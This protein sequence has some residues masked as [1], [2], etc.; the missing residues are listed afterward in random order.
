MSVEQIVSQCLL[1]K[2]AQC[3]KYCPIHT[4]IPEVM[5]LIKEGKIEEAKAVLFENN[6][7][8]AVCAMVCD[9]AAQCYGH[10]IK[11]FKN[12]P[13]PFFEIEQILSRQYLFDHEFSGRPSL[14]QRIGI[15]GGGPAGITAAIKLALKGYPITIF[16]AKER[17]GGVLRYGIP[18]VRLPKNLIDRLEELLLSLNVKIRP[19]TLIG[20]VL[21]IDRLLEDG[22]SALFIG[23]GVWNPKLLNI[24]GE[25]LGN[26]HYAIDYL[27]SPEAY[28]LDHEVAVIGAGNVAMDAAREARRLGHQVTVYYRRSLKQMSASKEE[29]EAAC[30]EG[31]VFELQNSPVRIEED[32]LWLER[33]QVDEEG[34]ISTIPNSLHK[35]SC[36]SVIIAVSQSPR[37]NIVDH[38]QN[39][40]T[41]RY[42]L[43]ISDEKGQTSR[44]G[45]FACGDVVT[46]AR[47]VVE[48]VAAAKIAAEAIDKYCQEKFERMQPPLSTR[49]RED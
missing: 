42:G 7:L 24:P 25:T 10:C 28:H 35:V 41:N 3:Q 40:Q 13:V 22:Y 16:E 38:T 14:H 37:S 23:T 5:K 17:I 19:N 29:Y 31:V 39:L 2:N 18:E 33:T 9:H 15:I 47:T 46:G 43:L 26:V 6:P 20:P 30:R 44:E 4:P 21:S 32:G 48:A 12:E 27:V 8:S 11:N 36:G 45:V 1:C 34:K 49:K